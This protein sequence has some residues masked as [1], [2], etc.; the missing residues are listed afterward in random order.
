MTDDDPISLASAYLD[1]EL[2]V[3]ARA[4]VDADPELLAEVDRLR[5]VRAVLSDVP[6]PSISARERH[7]ASALD[8]WDRLPDAERTGALRDVTPTG[9]DGAAAAGVAAMSAPSHTSSRRSRRGFQ[10][11]V[12]LGAAAAGLV[13]VLAGGL[14]LRSF[15]NGGDDSDASSADFSA[16]ADTEA[17][18]GV[19]SA[20][21]TAEAP[22]EALLDQAS[23]A[24]AP[25]VAAPDVE[26]DVDVA[27]PPPEGDLP[28]LAGPDDLA[29]F[30]AEAIGAPRSNDLP[31][32]ATVITEFPEEVVEAG[33]VLAADRLPTCLGADVVVGSAIYID[34]VV[35][36]G[37][38]ESRELALAYLADGCVRVATAPLP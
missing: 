32:G 38:D 22:G 2:E 15:D 31:D 7:L 36:V 4:R 12:W 20:D 18:A 14:L 24:G 25:P 5:Q 3:D 35:I 37:I 27:A 11:N 30:A 28:V 33:S 21:D 13:V 10:S 6:S 29:D 19:E 34:Q 26:T 9:A 1:G 8:A 23:E 17:P 16:T